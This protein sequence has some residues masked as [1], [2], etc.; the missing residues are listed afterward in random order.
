MHQLN[1]NASQVE[2]VDLGILLI[3]K[4]SLTVDR[5][6]TLFHFV[7]RCVK[8]LTLNLEGR[9]LIRKSKP[10]AHTLETLCMRDFEYEDLLNVMGM[11]QVSGEVKVKRNR[12]DYSEKIIA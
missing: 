12:F 9:K 6:I 11:C 3:R 5:Q 10:V 8:E 1:I 2:S 7:P 4:L